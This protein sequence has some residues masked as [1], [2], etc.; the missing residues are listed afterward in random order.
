M[1][2][3]DGDMAGKTVKTTLFPITMAGARLGVAPASEGPSRVRMQPP[4]IAEHTDALMAS[5]GYN[6]EQIRQLRAQDAV[7]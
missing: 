6:P 4:K 5:I 1:V 2:V 7:A 3:A